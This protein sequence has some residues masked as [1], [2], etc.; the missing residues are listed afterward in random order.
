MKTKEPIN[1][2]IVISAIT[3]LTIIEL[4]A[5]SQ[6]ING[7]FRMIVTV[8]IAGMAGKVMPQSKLK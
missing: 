3:A 5:M 8:A 2:W 6:G 1:K 7:T 4:Y